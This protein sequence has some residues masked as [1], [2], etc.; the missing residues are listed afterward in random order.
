MAT[1]GYA[2]GGISMRRVRQRAYTR[3]RGS[4][5]QVVRVILDWA[6][7]SCRA[8]WS[9]RWHAVSVRAAIS[10]SNGPSEGGQTVRAHAGE[11]SSRAEPPRSSS[12]EHTIAGD[13]WSKAPWCL[14]G[15]ATPRRWASKAPLL[16]TNLDTNP[17]E[18]PRTSA[19]TPISQSSNISASAPTTN[20]R[21]HP[22]ANLI[23]VIPYHVG[24]CSPRWPSL[25]SAASPLWHAPSRPHRWQLQRVYQ[26]IKCAHVLVQHVAQR[27]ELLLDL[28]FKLGQHLTRALRRHVVRLVNQPT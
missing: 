11:V 12:A 7:A 18:S 25:P 1:S 21:E 17:G 15:A 13:A 3:P 2:N 19:N 5:V 26:R 16:D 20:R 8:A 28:H 9:V 4:R 14:G 24:P 10:V 23:F 22:K 6:P 27:G